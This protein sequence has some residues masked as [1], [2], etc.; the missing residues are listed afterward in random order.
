MI[1]LHGREGESRSTRDGFLFSSFIL[2]GVACR[3][4]FSSP[5]A[6]YHLNSSLII[7]RLLLQIKFVDQLDVLLYEVE[8]ALGGKSR[9]LRRHTSLDG[10]EV[11]ASQVEDI[12][13][14]RLRAV[15]GF[16]GDEVGR[17]ALQIGLAAD[18]ASV[19]DGASN[20]VEVSS[21][22]NHFTR[23]HL[24]FPDQFGDAAGAVVEQDAQVS[25]GDDTT[26]AIGL[27]GCP[28]Q[29]AF[30][31]FGP[32]DTGPQVGDIILIDQGDHNWHL[33]CM[34]HRLAIARAFIDGDG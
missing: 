33:A 24:I 30:Q 6:H 5:I 19:R 21:T 18:D 11:D 26:L 34:R 3:R 32:L 1:A 17:L 13:V 20:V 10:G 4:R 8:R 16:L 14:D 9:F 12:V 29:G 31:H 27:V 7:H 2:I 28:H 23:P 25:T 22:R 15:T